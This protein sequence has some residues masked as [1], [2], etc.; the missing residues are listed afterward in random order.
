MNKWLYDVAAAS[1]RSVQPAN[2]NEASISVKCSAAIIKHNG[3]LKMKRKLFVWI[4]VFPS[5]AFNKQ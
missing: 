2:A 4:F 3:R 1:A 5:K